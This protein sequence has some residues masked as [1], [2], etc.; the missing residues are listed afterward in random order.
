VAFVPSFESAW[1]QGAES[2][3][4][5]D[6]YSR[7]KLVLRRQR[8]VHTAR[9]LGWTF[10]K[11]GESL[12]ADCL[13]A[14]IRLDCLRDLQFLDLL[15]A[16]PGLWRCRPVCLYH[17]EKPYVLPFPRAP[18][19]TPVLASFEGGMLAAFREGDDAFRHVAA[20]AP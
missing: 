15:R 16:T 5:L 8:I 2:D 6:E 10:L 18:A 11:V 9:S 7:R 3:L 14:G 17:V 13:V 1:G 12:P 19:E 4:H 20:G